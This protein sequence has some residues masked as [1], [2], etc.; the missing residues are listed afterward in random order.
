MQPVPEHFYIQSAV[1]PFRQRDGELEILL[2]TSRK[3]KRWVIP[4]GV[5]EPELALQASAVKEAMEEAGVEGRVFARSVGS[6]RYRKWGGVCTVEVY[7]MAV[8]KTHPAWDEDYRDREWVSLT[9]AVRRIEEPELKRI[10][11]SL[12]DFIRA[13]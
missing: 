1:I 9:E 6:Y 2:I 7:V 4:K 10:V 13:Q 3:K 5:K 12:P 11:G 8:E